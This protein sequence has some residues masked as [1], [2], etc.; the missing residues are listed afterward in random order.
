MEDIRGFWGTKMAGRR[1]Q[2]NLSPKYN[3]VITCWSPD[4]PETSGSPHF[5]RPSISE[6]GT[7]AFVAATLAARKGAPTKARSP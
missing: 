2:Q 1:E 3:N 5:V 4:A 6:L 7:G